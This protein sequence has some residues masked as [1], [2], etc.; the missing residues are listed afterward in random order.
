M[1]KDVKISLLKEHIDK[2]KAQQMQLLKGPIK[3]VN[4]E[5]DSLLT[6]IMKAKARYE[7]LDQH[8]EAD[9]QKLDRYYDV[10]EFEAIGSDLISRDVCAIDSIL[11][12]KDRRQKSQRIESNLLFVN[13]TASKRIL[14]KKASNAQQDIQDHI[15]SIET[16]KDVYLEQQ[17]S[18]SSGTEFKLSRTGSG[19]QVL[20]GPGSNRV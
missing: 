19:A 17:I 15:H 5:C 13:R 16:Q 6:Q 8:A 18:S 1:L 2:A 20:K 7:Q 4:R 3:K 14:D 10:Q 12:A 11:L 9:K